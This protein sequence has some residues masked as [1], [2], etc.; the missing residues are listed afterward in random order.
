MFFWVSLNEVYVDWRTCFCLNAM[1][2]P[3]DCWCKLS[4][5]NMPLRGALAFDMLIHSV[6]YKPSV[7]SWNARHM[8]VYKNQA[9]AT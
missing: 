2:H 1:L 6:N 4:Q 9:F 5:R 8:I 7:C 3:V